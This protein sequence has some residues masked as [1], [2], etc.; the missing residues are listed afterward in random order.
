ME[1][2]MLKQHLKKAAKDIR[3]KDAEDERSMKKAKP[4]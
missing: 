1:R 2:K 4:S 3:E